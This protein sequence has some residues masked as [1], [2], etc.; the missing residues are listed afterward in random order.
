MI[1]PQNFL[2]LAGFE[3]KI[4]NQLFLIPL[5]ILGNEYHGFINWIIG[6]L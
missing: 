5:K 3:P 1:A 6:E 4:I 2:G